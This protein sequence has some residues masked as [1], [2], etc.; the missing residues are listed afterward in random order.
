[1]HSPADVAHRAPRGPNVAHRVSG[2]HSAPPCPVPLED[3]PPWPRPA[4]SATAAGPGGRVIL[5]R[6]SSQ[7]KTRPK[8]S[9]SYTSK[10]LGTLGTQAVSRRLTRIKTLS[11]RKTG[12]GTHFQ[13]TP[14]RTAFLRVPIF[15]TLRP[16]SGDSGRSG[17][18]TGAGTGEEGR[19][20]RP[21]ASPPTFPGCPPRTP[22]P[23]PTPSGAARPS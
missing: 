15:G 18:G 6:S 3:P 12:V 16:H 14:C 20:D 10:N 5:A 7:K 2:G 1:M 21:P 8:D 17:V 22:W 11:P 23:W 4:P 19:S 13:K 9:S